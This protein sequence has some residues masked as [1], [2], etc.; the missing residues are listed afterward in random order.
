MVLRD[1]LGDDIHQGGWL[2]NAWM[3]AEDS[4]RLAGGAGP[5]DDSGPGSRAGSRA[6]SGAGLGP[7]ASAQQ[8]HAVDLVQTQ[9]GLSHRPQNPATRSTPARRAQARAATSAVTRLSSFPF[10]I[11]V[12]DRC[13]T[14]T[15][16]RFP[17]V[18]GPSGKSL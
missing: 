12:I 8:A 16:A 3:T 4:S 6:G 15:M 17:F 11:Y 7:T 5:G 13:W 10:A 14:T 2:F 18:C 1:E 9:V